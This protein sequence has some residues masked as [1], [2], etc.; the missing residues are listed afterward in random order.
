MILSV[1]FG[2]GRDAATLFLMLMPHAKQHGNAPC[3]VIQPSLPLAAD[4]M[5]SA[6]PATLDAQRGEVVR[7]RTV[8]LQMHTRQWIGTYA[9]QGNGDYQGEL[10][11]ALRA[12][13]SYLKL[14]ALTPEAALVRLDGQYGDAVAIPLLIEAGVHLVTR[15]RGYRVLEHPQIQRVLAHPPTACVTQV[16]TNE[17]VELFDGGWL[18]I[19]EK[20][21][22]VRVIVARHRAPESGKKISVGKRI[23]E[24]VYEIFLTTLPLEGFL[25]EDVLDLYHGR[26]LLRR[27]LQMKM[28]KK[29]PIAGVRI[30]NADKNSGRLHV[31]GCGNLRLSLGQIMQKAELRAIEWASPKESPPMLLALEEPVEEYGSWE[32]AAAFGRATGRFGA[33]SFTLQEDGKLRCPAGASLWLSEIRQEN[34]FTQ[35]AVYLA[36]QTDCLRCSLREQCLASGAKGDRARRVSAVRR[37]LPPPAVV[38]HKPV[39]LGPIRW[40]DVAGRALRRIWMAHW[41]TQYVE[42]LSLSPLPPSVPPPLRPPRA[43]RSHYRWNWSDRL[44]R[45][46][47][48]GPPRLR[49]T[50]AGVPAALALK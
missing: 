13:A 31:N 36:Y 47:G 33:E 17:E 27:C 26:G 40:V 12:I 32:W 43:M 42:I 15:A 37:L 9:G 11:L 14:F 3:P 5:R 35:R 46:A 2:I 4:L 10:A 34:A 6:L 19:K 38:E 28:S 49:V 1:E 41:R 39:L 45:N 23:G 25:V 29:T 21:P 22:Q 16:R 30:R 8:A 7:T 18:S 20:V 50:V 44:A 24:W 48:F